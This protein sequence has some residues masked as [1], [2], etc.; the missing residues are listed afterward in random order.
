MIC[1]PGILCLLLVSPLAGGETEEVLRV[2]VAANLQ[3]VHQK[4]EARFEALT[5]TPVEAVFASTGKLYAQIEHG[6]PFDVFLSADAAHVAQL[7][8]KGL[9]VEA[10]RFTYAL[11]RLALYS[12]TPGVTDPKQALEGGAFQHLA[13]AKADLAPY[14][15]AA[16]EVLEHLKLTAKTREKLVFGDSVTQACQFVRTG[17]AELGFVAY[18]QVIGE[19]EAV[20]WLAPDTLHAPI[21]QDAVLLMRAEHK[22][23]A[24]EY[25][26]FLKSAESQRIFEVHGYGAPREQE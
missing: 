26:E 10:S 6:A 17:A 8:E 5:G 14:G 16:A 19:P 21:R 9:A 11:G 15:A 18:S 2:A 25:L 1:L 23:A 22:A 24:R 12:A 7:V 4:L 13:V 20:Y 3:G